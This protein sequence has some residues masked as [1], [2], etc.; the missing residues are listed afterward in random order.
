MSHT[1]NPFVIPT[2]FFCL[3]VLGCY[4]VI[5]FAAGAHLVSAKHLG[6]TV[7]FLNCINMLGGSFFHSMIGSLMDFF[8]TGAT[9][10]DG[11]RFYDLSVYKS[12]LAVVP[13]SAL[14]G[15]GIVCFVGISIKKRA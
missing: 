5:V 1:Y 3:G 6:V 9:A 8:W 13:I 11:L 7:A 15:A 12:A 2:L 14:V 10:A 4:Q